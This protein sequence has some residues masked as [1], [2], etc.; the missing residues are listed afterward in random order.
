[1]SALALRRARNGAFALAALGVLLVAMHLWERELRDPAMVTGW[2]LFALVLL[3]ALYGVKKALPFLPLRGSTAWMQVHSWAGFLSV[4]VFALH[5]GVRLPTG[6][7]EGVLALAF[8]LVAGSGILGLALARLLPPMLRAR[9]EPILYSR[10]P[11]IRREL[12]AKAAAL[13]APS[14]ALADFHAQHLAAW[15]AQPADALAHLRG[16]RVPLQRRLERIES[17]FRYLTESEVATARALID[18]V[19]QKDLL[20]A[21][22]AG[23]TALRAWTMVHVPVTG[24]L[25]VLAA[26]HALTVL[27]FRG[28]S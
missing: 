3:L 23:Q 28:G 22:H 4:A 14:K 5:A 16:S 13:V 18:V 27:A 9:G 25:V 1:M 21:Q 7:L 10:I 6:I 12:A 8:V 15:L 20:D 11:V 17:L 2:T 24:A 26:L 19:K